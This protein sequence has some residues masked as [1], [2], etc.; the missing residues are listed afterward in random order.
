MAQRFGDLDVNQMEDMSHLSL[1]ERRRILAQQCIRRRIEN[2]RI[3]DAARSAGYA[4]ISAAKRGELARQQ[5]ARSDF[6][7]ITWNRS[8]DFGTREPAL[9]AA[10]I[11]LP[12]LARER[13]EQYDMETRSEIDVE[14]DESVPDGGG[15]FASKSSAETSFKSKLSDNSSSSRFNIESKDDG[16]KVTRIQSGSSLKIDHDGDEDDEDD[17][18]QKE[19]DSEEKESLS[20]VPKLQQWAHAHA[21]SRNRPGEELALQREV[22]LNSFKEILRGDVESEMK[23]GMWETRQEI[24]RVKVQ[25]Q[26]RMAMTQ[27][28][29]SSAQVRMAETHADEALE[30]KVTHSRLISKERLRMIQRKSDELV[31]VLIERQKSVSG[32]LEK[33]VEQRA[34][35]ALEKLECTSAYRAFC[36]D[37]QVVECRKFYK[38]VQEGA[39]VDVG[40]YGL[41]SLQ[42]KA[43][44]RC[45]AQS[46]FLRTLDLSHNNIAD[47]GCVNVGNEL[48]PQNRS[49][50]VLKLGSNNVSSIGATIIFQALT[51]S[52]NYFIRELDL[53]HNSIGNGKRPQVVALNQS[54]KE[55]FTKAGMQSLSWLD[56][57]FNQ[58][59]ASFGVMFAKLLEAHR[60]IIPPTTTT[61][62][63]YDESA[64]KI[65]RQRERARSNIGRS[66]RVVRNSQSLQQQQ[67]QQQQQHEHQHAATTTIQFLPVSV[68]NLM[69]VNLYYNRLGSKSGR[70]IARA[71]S[72]SITLLSLDL[73]MNNLDSRTGTDL[74]QSLIQNK[75]VRKV[76]VA[77]NNIGQSGIKSLSHALIRNQTIEH[78]D[79]R[80]N[81]LNIQGV[82][83][84]ATAL[85]LNNSLR[86][87][88]VSHSPITLL[89]TVK[90]SDQLTCVLSGALEPEL[91]DTRVMHVRIK[92][93]RTMSL[94]SILARRHA[95]KWN[96]SKLCEPV[97]NPQS[98]MYS[99]YKTNKNANPLEALMPNSRKLT[100]EELETDTV[101]VAELN[102]S[103]HSQW[104]NVE[105]SDCHLYIV[106]VLLAW[107]DH[108]L[109][110]Y[111][112][113]R[114]CLSGIMCLT[115]K[116]FAFID[117]NI[118]QLSISFPK[119][120][121]LFK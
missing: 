114:F 41:N 106:V 90:R 2:K 98:L 39:L 48:I 56:L 37:H 100:L 30:A 12:R 47:Q 103:T 22:L 33:K 8:R 87:L 49:L 53:S 59:D 13:K 11:T 67:Q 88:L 28:D 108:A 112:L 79:V 75:I 38:Q 68:C 113:N 60:P 36:E 101:C 21:A 7:H 50:V 80:G 85:S 116:I 34:V 31:E 107:Q 52:E 40:N 46:S 105:V 20:H 120:V 26:D 121:S 19:Q 14:V 10:E 51:D 94:C 76:A 16:S 119:P 73:G 77:D 24:I 1:L 15:S 84:L 99:I 96:M 54:I 62:M 93:Q 45:L 82:A 71:L 17:E 32:D 97:L 3:K 43:L 83:E 6:E 74:A 78:L 42:A 117:M 109:L 111:S 57:S 89:Q 25:C 23:N 18:E 29:F 27:E 86:V 55:Y 115:R 35:G 69:H 4:S 72:S 104:Y 63:T 64:S 102:H 9:T 44:T 118:Y 61:T 95:R 58:L 65:S 92:L 81:P 66:S 110:S 70:K 5:K 91:M